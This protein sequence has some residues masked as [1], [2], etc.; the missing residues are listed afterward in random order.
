MTTDYA[1]QAEQMARRARLASRSVAVASTRQKNEA[2]AAIADALADQTAAIKAEN[3]RDLDAA[4]KA[5]LSTA[6]VDRLT[7]TDKRIEA[8][9]AG[10]REIA[11]QEDPVGQVIEQSTRP[12]GLDLQRVRVPIG[13]IFIIF[14]SRPNVTIDAAGLCL[15]SGN[16]CILRGGKEAAF[17]NAALYRAI[18]SGLV[19]A[20]LPETA[21]QLVEAADHAFVGAMLKLDRWIDLV[22]PRGGERLIRAVVEQ[23]T[24]PVIK[25][26]KGVCHV[27]ID[28]FA[29]PAMAA[30]IALNAK[31]QRPGV[32]NAMETLLVHQAQAGRPLADLLKAMAARGVQIRGCERTCAVFP[33]A[34]PAAEADWE[35]EYLDLILAVRVVD[36]I[37]D[38]IEHI[39][40]YGSAH[41]DA[42]V[43]ADPRRAEEF[44]RRVDS[45]SVMVNASTR[46]SDGGE[47]GLGAEVGISTDKLH[48]RGPMGIRDLTT[49]KYV[50]RGNGQVRT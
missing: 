2:L 9:A 17:S 25:H 11:A 15:K 44:V 46:F 8:M 12:N 33:D 24:I 50:V 3:A 1:A 13:V 30:E 22:I 18:R 6:M 35:A 34:R 37:E 19:A 26:Y 48:A 21:V 42:I 14:E 28:E 27:Y 38:A 20:G 43:T 31:C 39:A 41:T 32:C 16:A 40:R 47:Y 23:S 36:N 4:A 7:L 10:L 49:Y 29:D 5:G 45:S